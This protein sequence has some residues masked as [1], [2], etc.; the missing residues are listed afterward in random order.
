MSETSGTA[1]TTV[2]R[3]CVDATVALAQSLTP[4][5]L[6]T[7]VPATPQWSVRDVLGHAAG[8]AGDTLAGRMDAAPSPAWTSRHVAER[9]G[10]TIPELIEELRATEASIAASIEGNDRPAI[11]WDRSVHLADLHEALGLDAPPEPTWRPV[12][13]AVAAWRLAEVPLTVRCGEE[14]F[15]AGGPEVGVEPYELFRAVFSRRS[16][17]QLREWT[18]DLVTDEQL[19]TIGIFG[20]RDDDQP[21]P[22]AE[23]QTRPT[24]GSGRSVR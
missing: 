7:A 1:W 14:T 4:E 21:V 12:L 24:S 8:V 3:D 17:R 20:P 6:A 15:G 11:V 2:Y 22:R 23:Q 9:A 10:R 19:D 5:Q 18:G 13:G 16:R